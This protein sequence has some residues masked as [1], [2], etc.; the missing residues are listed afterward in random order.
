[1][2]QSAVMNHMTARAGLPAAIHHLAAGATAQTPD[3]AT[4]FK[5]S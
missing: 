3:G 5:Q 4:V 1:M 2:L